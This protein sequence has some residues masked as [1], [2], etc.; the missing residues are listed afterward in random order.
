MVL[1][2][3][4]VPETGLATTEVKVCVILYDAFSRDAKYIKLEALR[5]L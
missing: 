3:Y 1:S 2:F 5:V 4:F